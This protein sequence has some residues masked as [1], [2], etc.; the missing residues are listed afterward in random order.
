MS[1]VGGGEVD[2]ALGHVLADGDEFVDELGGAGQ[3]D[4]GGCLGFGAASG[5]RPCGEDPFVLEPLAVLAG[6]QERGECLAAGIGS[7]FVAERGE[8]VGGLAR[9]GERG[10]RQ[11]FVRRQGAVRC[12]CRGRF[13]GPPRARQPGQGPE[14]RRERAWIGGGSIIKVGAVAGTGG[15]GTGRAGTGPWSSTAAVI[16]SLSRTRDSCGHGGLDGAQGVRDV[17]QP[18]RP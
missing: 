17:E 11:R 6:L 15:D 18:G 4:G 5:C 2:L 3:R 14:G 10:V 13:G 7:D 9:G 1:L 16:T 8:D 12:G